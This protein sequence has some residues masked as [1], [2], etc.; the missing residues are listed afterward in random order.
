MWP[1]WRGAGGSA[2]GGPGL[3]LRRY[4]SWGCASRHEGDLEKEAILRENLNFCSRLC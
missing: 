3:L 1:E 4:G 2:G